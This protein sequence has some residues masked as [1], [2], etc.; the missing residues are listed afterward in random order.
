MIVTVRYESG[1]VCDDSKFCA[2]DLSNLAYALHLAN[3]GPWED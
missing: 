3:L 1:M 2:S